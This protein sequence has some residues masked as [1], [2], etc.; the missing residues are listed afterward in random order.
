MKVCYWFGTLAE[1]R[2]PEKCNDCLAKVRMTCDCNGSTVMI[3]DKPI[4]SKCGKEQIN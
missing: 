3:K 2:E 4:C 1:C